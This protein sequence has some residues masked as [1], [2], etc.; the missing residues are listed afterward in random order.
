MDH[1]QTL[2]VEDLVLNESFNNWV[3]NAS[4]ADEQ[5]WQ[6]WLAN[7]PDKHLL[8]EQ[9]RQL[10]LALSSKEI[11]LPEQEI[12]LAW[13]SLQ[14]ALQDR[15]YPGSSRKFTKST[16]FRK[17]YA[18]AAVFALLL[19]SGLFIWKV[20]L[21]SPAVHYHTKFGETKTIH[22]PD[23]SQVILNGNTTLRYQANWSQAKHREVWLKGEAY[24]SVK[25]GISAGNAKFIVHTTKLDVEVLGT[26]FNVMDRKK[27]TRVVLD[28]GQVKISP[29]LA[30]IDKPLFMKP[31]ELVEY[32]ST[33]AALIR[34]ST[35]TQRYSSWKHKKM[36]FDA[37]SM[38]EI[39][40]QIEA[41]Y[42]L[43]V[44]FADPAL[45]QRKLTGTIPSDN[46]NILLLTLSKLFNIT[47][48]KDNHQI[49]IQSSTF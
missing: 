46:I 23:G 8:V 48:Y 41:T 35:D 44:V 47:T 22:L 21:Y 26:Q 4:K 20:Y 11:P 31:G 25:K 43:K 42:G 34:K 49:I 32:S 29:L 13:R 38:Q 36:V 16:P 40:E 12:A 18:V 1:L 17:W 9:A 45:A 5:Y 3:K 19:I 28:E 30:T 10:V 6:K 39:A 33:K 27:S 2:T 7:N 14:E 37:T 15:K 24:F